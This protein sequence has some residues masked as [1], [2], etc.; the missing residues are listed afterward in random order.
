MDLSK[1]WK[2]VVETLQDGLIVVDPGG[3]IVFVN[4]AAADLTGYAPE[5]L[6]GRS[7]RI[8]GCTGC[9][10][11]GRGAGETWC[12]LFDRGQVS[13]KQCTITDRSRRSVHI[14]KS[15][16]VL[17]DADGR[18]IGAVET[19]KDMSRFIRQQ[20]EIA[21]LRKSC[22]LD[23]GYHGIIGESLKIQRLFE[24]IESV[25]RSDAP[26]LVLG[27]SGTGKELV[28]R[29]IHDTSVRK[30]GPFIKVNCA[31]LNEN[32]LESELFG[33]VK[34]AYTGAERSRIG[35][36]EA[37]HGGTILLDEIGDIPLT[38]QVK[39][40]RV[41]E[42]REIE[43]VGDHQPIPVDVRIITATNRDLEE[44]IRQ[45]AFREDLFFRINVFPI[46]C[47]SLA[48][49]PDDIPLIVK[50]F[51][52]QQGAKAGK[53]ISGLTPGAMEALLAYS[54]PGNVRELRNAVEY[55]YVLCP[56]EWIGRE[57]LPPKI[58][59]MNGLSAVR[60]D[61]ATATTADAAARELLVHT[62]RMTGG[63]QSEAARRLKVSRVTIWKR[64]KKYGID[65]D[66]EIRQQ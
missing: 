43:R 30:E 38:T 66:A 12:G 63:N 60:D 15:A 16:R 53:R 18:V 14:L 28:A 37:A 31:A 19:L 24:L 32:L 48:E 11:K 57:H 62:L 41:L 59:R 9:E 4:P 5:E 55:A 22:R 34:G 29:A 46:H 3:T 56:G 40:L 61:D 25:A 58:S 8:L 49:R 13:I 21:A 47:P 50:S 42:E 17:K 2:T 51:I 33:H 26:V 52:D 39:L 1:H 45:G 23:A 10:I 44:L 64:I 54:W 27:E 20:Q 7:C 36:F 6:V 65:L 35:R